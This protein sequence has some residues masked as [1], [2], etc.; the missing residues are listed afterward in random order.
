M[1]VNIYKNHEKY[2]PNSIYSYYYYKVLFVIF[3][4]FSFLQNMVDHQMPLP[5]V[6]T[7][8]T[9]LMSNMIVLLMP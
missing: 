4:S 2:M 8:T 7:L 1:L 3:I 5:L 9:T 6:N